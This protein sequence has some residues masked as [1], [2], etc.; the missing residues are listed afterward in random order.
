MHYSGK[1]FSRLATSLLILRGKLF[2]LIVLCGL[3]INGCHPRQENRNTRLE[4]VA[5]NEEVLDYMKTFDG[6]GAL[7]DNSPPTSPQKVLATFNFADDL[8]L[9]L[10]LS[11]PEVTQPVFIHFDHRG[12]LWVVQY[13]QYP[14]PAGLKI[15]SIDQHI[16]ARFDKIP[17][18]PPGGMKGADKITL[19]TDTDG[20]G[21]FET[22]QDVFTGLN[23]ATSVALGRKKIWVL[24]P[25]YLLAYPDADQNGIPEGDPEVHLRGFGLEDTHAVANN[26]RWGPD[27]WLYGA[28]GSTCTANISSS[29]TKNVSFNGQVIWRYHPES[30]VFEIFAEGGGNTFDIEIDDKGRLYSGDNG[31]NR[32]LYYKQGAYHQRNLGKHGAFTNAY[33]FGFLPEMEHHGDMARFTHAFVRYEEQSLPPRYHNQMIAIN[34]LQRYVLLSS[35]DRNGSTFSNT[36]GLRILET[37]DPWFRPVDIITGPDGFIYLADWYDSRLTHVDPRDTWS[38]TTGRIYRLRSRKSKPGISKFDISAYSNDQLI[39]LFSNKNRWFR[40]QAMLELGNRKDNNLVP[41]LLNVLKTDTGQ[42]ALEALWAIHLSNGFNDDAAVTAL[43]HSDPYVRMW[44]VRLLGDQKN[45][46]IEIAKE[47]ERLSTSEP[48]PETRSQLAASAKRFPAH[49]AIPVIRNLLMNDSDASD[50]DIPLQLWWAL[51]SKSISDR[52]Q[53]VSIF[54]NE[55]IWSKKIVSQFILSRLA[56]R[57][58]ME[59]GDENY[60]ACADILNQASSSKLATSFVDGLREGLRGRDVAAL[61]TALVKSMKPYQALMDKEPLSFL[62][63]Q[64]DKRAI[65]AALKIITDDNAEVI[66]RLAYIRVFGEINHPESVE[67]LLKL[68]ESGRS[69]AAIKQAALEALPRYDDPQTGVRVTAAYPDKLRS[70]PMVRYAALSLLACRQEWTMNLLEAI[71]RK[72][73]PG[74]KFIAHTIDKADVP[75]P[76]AQQLMLHPSPSISA[77]VTKLWPEVLP[78]SAEEKNQQMEKV[79]QLL[80][81]G[82]GDAASGKLIFNSLCGRCHRL[83]GEG[84]HM[85]PELTGYDRK[86]LNDLFTNI[87]DPGAYVREGYGAYQI[88]T[89]D[90]RNMLGILK[91]DN[92]STLVLQLFYGSTVVIPKDQ[93][94]EI[95]DQKVSIM[96]ERLL[97]NLPDQQIRDLVAFMT[98]LGD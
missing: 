69:S 90:K 46:S 75:F 41:Q 2:L 50:P 9:D 37:T 21:V 22:S 67:V 77:A 98:G 60:A 84:E 71:D 63:R 8:S 97:D 30:R 13:N 27:G 68:I 26:L 12:R 86:N 17:E 61:S 72:K 48:H 62:L 53:V 70:E 79:S 85:G 65:D 87:I 23:I 19:F 57:W 93:V 6:R 59:G 29:V 96:P 33:A 89:R 42:V 40:Q 10:V 45:T 16:R 36:D 18:P 51:E 64:D 76:I 7:T 55:K 83:F 1:Y 5:G 28:Q 73:L 20:D 94:V 31:N 14:Y 52:S 82:K 35:F 78:V 25:P 4:E 47:L 56:Q 24:D 74:E 92:G 95:N 38:K 80:K 39:G 3:V 43:R 11:E 34:P 32:G 54:R 88:I 66:E 49:I 44:A 91:A 58:M 15:T 81:T